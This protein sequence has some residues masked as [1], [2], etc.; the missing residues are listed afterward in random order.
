MG[1]TSYMNTPQKGTPSQTNTWASFMFSAS[2]PSCIQ[3]LCMR[4]IQPWAQPLRSSLAKENLQK[5]SSTHKW[6]H[7]HGS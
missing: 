7:A 1:R 3:Q 6:K 5:C 2:H 4:N